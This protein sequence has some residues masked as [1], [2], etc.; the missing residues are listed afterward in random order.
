MFHKTFGD[1]VSKKKRDSVKHLKIIEKILRKQ[2]LRVESFLDG[3]ADD[4][5]VY[6]FNPSKNTTFDGVRIY[7][8][9]GQVAFRVQKESKTHPYGRAYPL[10]IE[11]MFED[12]LTDDGINEQ[13]AGQKVIESVGKEVRRFF[14][15]SLDAERNDRR[16]GLNAPKEGD[17]MQKASVADFSTMINH[18]M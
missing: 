12:F 6:C 5:Y 3:D 14:D 11:E 7:T 4:P 2:G 9:A 8:I 16:F 10:N 17:V 18:K 1:F 15:R 13:E